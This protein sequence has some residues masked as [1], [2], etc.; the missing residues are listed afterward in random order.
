MQDDVHAMHR[1]RGQRP[2][3]AATG[4][5]QMTVEVVNVCGG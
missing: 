2:P 1:P 4:V 5:Q 3:F